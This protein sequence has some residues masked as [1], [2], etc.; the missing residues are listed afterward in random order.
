MAAARA[1]TSFHQSRNLGTHPAAGWID[2]ARSREPA[3]T[4]RLMAR[5][6]SGVVPQH[7]PMMEAPAAI[8]SAVLSPK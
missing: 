4:D 5:M 8:S 7:P 6:C 2:Q 3:S 1:G